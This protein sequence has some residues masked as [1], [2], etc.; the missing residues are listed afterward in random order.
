MLCLSECGGGGEK[1]HKSACANKDPSK[2]LI[3]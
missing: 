1:E 3:H 2:V